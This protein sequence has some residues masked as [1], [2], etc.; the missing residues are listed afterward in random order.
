[1]SGISRINS[2]P[3]RGHL[4]IKNVSGETIPAR[5]IVA[6]GAGETTAA[7]G[8]RVFHV[9]KP[10]GSTVFYAI[11]GN[12]DI[13][14]GEFG[15]A[16][17]PWEPTWVKY[18]TSD[19]PSAGDEWGVAS[20]SFKLDSGGKEFFVYA[21]DSGNELA[22]VGLKPGSG[23]GSNPPTVIEI[24]VLGLT[25]GGDLTLK[26]WTIDGQTGDVTLP[27]NASRSNAATHSAIQSHPAITS[28]S[29]Y[30]VTGSLLS[31][32]FYIVFKNLDWDVQLPDSVV[33]NF[34]VSSHASVSVGFMTR[35]NWLA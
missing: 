20:G 14:D 27:Y 29:D 7:D 30:D 24:L 3:S 12:T 9:E 4:R 33:D 31:S 2:N 28:R 5:S 6:L 19:T 1:M 21:V 35:H 32:R 16:V 11:T 23:G 18:D 10:S 17:V 26:D 13:S 8:A 15:T 34:V 25:T 22:C